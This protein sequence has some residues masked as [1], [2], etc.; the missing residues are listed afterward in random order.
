[1][2]DQQQPIILELAPLP[3]EQV[4]PF[5]LLGVDK[6]AGREE[7]EAAWAKRVIGARK[8]HHRIALEDVNWAREAINDPDRRLK[9]DLTSLNPDSASGVLRILAERFSLDGPTWQPHD[10]EQSLADYTP[11][12]EVPEIDQVRQTV[13][14][15]ELPMEL[16][17]VAQI[18]QRFIPTT[19][20]PWDPNLVPELT[21][22]T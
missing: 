3:R 2:N 6:S 4:G 7:I 14:L 11:A 18:L 13:T 1:M 15:P 16:P 12:I 17:A 10:I 8:G 19:F 20:D 22:E 5:L 21:E 9:A